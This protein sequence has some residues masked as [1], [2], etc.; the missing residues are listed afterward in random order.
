M[1]VAK[2]GFLFRYFDKA[3]CALVVIAFLGSVAYVLL[4]LGSLP[5]Q[6]DVE[7]ITQALQELEQRQGTEPPPAQ[8]P[9]LAS[10]VAA[11]FQPPEPPPPVRDPMLPPPPVVYEQQP[12]GPSMEFVLQFQAPLAPGTVEIQGNPYLFDILE[13]PADGD[14]TKVRMES[15]RWEGAVR[16][17]GIAGEAKHIYP[18]AVKEGAGQTAYPPVKLSVEPQGRGLNVSFQPDPRLRGTDIEVSGY[19]IWRRNWDEPLSQYRRVRR[20]GS[21]E[22]WLDETVAPG[23][24]YGYKVRTVG[25]NTYPSEGRFTEPVAA[26]SPPALDFAFTLHGTDRVRFEIVKRTNAGYAMGSF[27]TVIGEGIGGVEEQQGGTVVDFQTGRYLVDFHP[28]ATK[29]DSDMVSARVV[30]AGEDGILHER[31][32]GERGYEPLW[33]E[34]RQAMMSRRTGRFPGR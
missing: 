34:A 12:V 16:I 21:A 1:P 3:I 15:K 23:T 33:Q 11:S 27:W 18:V 5:Q 24:R 20:T 14:Y 19:E 22:P 30:Y 29:P 17:V 32:R 8:Q 25:Q 31:Y 7:Q 4:R 28:R 6:I 13:H 10:E 2:R 26:T 9:Q